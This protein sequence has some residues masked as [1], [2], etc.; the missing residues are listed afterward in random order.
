MSLSLDER[1][2]PEGVLSE[3]SVQRLGERDDFTPDSVATASG[4][5]S[6][7]SQQSHQGGPVAPSTSPGTASLSDRPEQDRI[8]DDNSALSRLPRGVAGRLG[9]Y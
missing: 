6:C 5:E 3:L 1:K 4:H 2:I 8:Q 7:E 9:L